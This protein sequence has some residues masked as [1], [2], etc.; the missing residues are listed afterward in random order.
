[1]DNSAIVGNEGVL[2]TRIVN[3]LVFASDKQFIA[4]L[5][6]AGLVL[7]VSNDLDID[8]GNV[9]QFDGVTTDMA[10]AILHKALSGRGEHNL[11]AV[12]I[13]LVAIFIL[14]NAVLQ[15]FQGNSITNV[16]LIGIV[17][18]GLD[19]NAGRRNVERCL[20]A[21][22]NQDLTIDISLSAI[23]FT[24]GRSVQSI[25]II[26]LGNQILVTTKAVALDNLC[27]LA[28]IKCKIDRAWNHNFATGLHV[29][30]NDIAGTILGMC[31]VGCGVLECNVPTL[32][33]NSKELDSILILPAG[34]KLLGSRIKANQ[35]VALRQAHLVRA[36]IAGYIAFCLVENKSI[37]IGCKHQIFLHHISHVYLSLTVSFDIFWV[38][39][40]RAQKI[41]EGT[42][43][44]FINLA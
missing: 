6:L 15:A 30:G 1:M 37:F 36:Y 31:V 20:G 41:V 39:G 19:F 2:G 42:P 32:R 25:G 9:G 3:H 22:D 26:H 13:S 34:D 27:H 29:I 35:L 24:L 28:R 17:V 4:G 10:V 8:A 23:L 7:I 43:L 16:A 40:A 11:G 14:Q 33:S 44:T 12:N 38:C 5:V 21:L 18:N